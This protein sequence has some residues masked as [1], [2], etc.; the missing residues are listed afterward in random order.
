[1]LAREN[2]LRKAN[3]IT[4]VY[5]RGNY[6]AVSGVLSV[7]ALSS[8]RGQTR[9]VVVVGKKISK[10]AVVRNKIRRRLIGHLQAHWATLRAGY[11]I[12]VN[13]H[14]DLSAVPMDKIAQSL[15][16]ALD[17]AGVITS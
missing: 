9:V 14:T 7:K 12:V 4:R 2:R 15:T 6:G 3:E 8:G 11:D 5:K 17:R 10:K 1:M 16:Q 13:V